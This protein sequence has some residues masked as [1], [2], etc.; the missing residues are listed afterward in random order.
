MEDG[1]RY[2]AHDKLGAEEI[3]PPRRS[4]DNVALPPYIA[5]QFTSILMEK[6]LQPLSRE[7]LKGLEVLAMKNQP[8]NW[9]TIFLVVFIPMHSFEPIL[10]HEVDFTKRRQHPVSYGAVS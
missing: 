6:V 5:F 10:K 2:A 7:V 8:S 4:K 9:F 1:W 3:S